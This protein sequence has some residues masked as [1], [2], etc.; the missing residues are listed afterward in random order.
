LQK[1]SKKRME[2]KNIKGLLNLKRSGRKRSSNGDWCSVALCAGF[3]R[4]LLGMV[5]TD[6][7]LLG[8]FLGD[9]LRGTGCS[10]REDSGAVCKVA[11]TGDG[12]GGKEELE[13][14]SDSGGK[15]VMELRDG[16]DYDGKDGSNEDGIDSG[17][18]EDREPEDESDE[19][20]TDDVEVGRLLAGLFF[21]SQC[22][23]DS[24][25]VKDRSISCRTLE[26]SL[27]VMKPDPSASAV[28]PAL[29][30][31]SR[32]HLVCFRN[33]AFWTAAESQSVQ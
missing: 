25:T 8:C 28:S 10:G 17:G 14:G 20:G 12:G 21:D 1:K 26:L 11:A 19:D 31:C 9:L 22:T 2:S 3:G 30:L 6:C 23:I 27:T 29:S 24:A 13:D 7:N 4:I 32:Y 5:T 16:S 33:F 18:K 15:D